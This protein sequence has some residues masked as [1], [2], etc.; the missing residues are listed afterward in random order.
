M[1][2]PL[3]VELI[4]MGMVVVV[5]MLRVLVLVV[6]HVAAPAATASFKCGDA[7]SGATNM[8]VGAEC[9]LMMSDVCRCHAADRGDG[10]DDIEGDSM[11]MIRGD[12]KDHCFVC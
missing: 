1:L 9:V 10:G 6:E 7:A 8:L 3:V 12:D 4:Q 2:S 11:P 5:M